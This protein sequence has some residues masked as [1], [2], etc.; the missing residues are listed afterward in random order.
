MGRR[1]MIALA[2]M[3]ILLTAGVGLALVQLWRVL[4]T[5][6]NLAESLESVA[7]FS[8]ER[9]RPMMR[10]LD[11][12]DEA[13]LESHPLA[14]RK[15][16]SQLRKKHCQAF[17]GYLRCLETDFQAVCWATKAL[18]LQSQTDR[19]DLAALL[20]RSQVAFACG[21]MKVQLRVAL[22]S[23]GIGTVSVGDLLKQFD[24]MRL[25]LRSL[26]PVTMS[27]AA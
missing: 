24:G 20:L 1:K 25:E 19:P 22:Y 14:T 11:G 9:Y 7:D 2:V 6:R 15:M 4:A 5:P 13:F 3:L 17:R 26:T 12:S 27:S 23:H 16:V 21:V 10:L 18:M 8:T